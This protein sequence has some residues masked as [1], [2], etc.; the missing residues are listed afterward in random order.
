MA[1]DPKHWVEIEDLTGWD[2]QPWHPLQG[3]ETL[4][5]VKD[6]IDELYK[7]HP[8]FND[9]Q[10]DYIYSRNNYKYVLKGIP[11]SPKLYKTLFKRKD[12]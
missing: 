1:R 2:E 12:K 8:L 3:F 11:K 6:H 5:D 9:L 4:N 10:I 7:Q